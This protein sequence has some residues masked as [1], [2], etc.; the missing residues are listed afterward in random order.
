MHVTDEF[1]RTLS[2]EAQQLLRR[3]GGYGRTEIAPHA[4]EWEYARQSPVDA[5]R[6]ACAA[7]FGS[8][9]LP[10]SFGGLALPFSAKMRL[11]EE[12]SRYDL[13]F[14]FALV[15]QQNVLLRIAE[16]APAA[17]A[18]ALVPRMV[19]GELIGCTAMSEPTT[20]SDFGA[21]RTQA[22]RVRGGW[23]LTGEKAGSPTPRWP[24]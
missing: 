14:A 8:V 3:A 7:G 4:K 1:D 9:E 10:S 19:T 17:L 20:G 13:A 22:T 18:Q 6:R 2:A 23:E 16:V 5:I 21:I 12:F 15:Q 11:A 24:T